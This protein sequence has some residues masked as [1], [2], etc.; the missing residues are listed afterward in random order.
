MRP[1]RGPCTLPEGF[2]MNDMIS[3]LM[4]STADLQEIVR[5]HAENAC[6]AMEAASAAARKA[7]ELKR[8]YEQTEA[9]FLVEITLT[10]DGKNAE[11]RKAQVEAALMKA[12]S[13]GTLARPYAMMNAARYE[14]DDTE[15]AR[16]Q[17]AIRFRASEVA[18]QMQAAAVRLAFKWNDN[19]AGEW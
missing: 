16:E 5:S 12:R 14:A 3:A 8:A 17:M 9:E 4:G 6:L 10:A 15:M 7:T 19:E 2:R 13:T 11:Q 18:G 1:G